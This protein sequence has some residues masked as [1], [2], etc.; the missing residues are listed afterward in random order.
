[1]RN[2]TKL[3][4]LTGFLGSGKTTFLTNILN[5]LAG[6]KV[7]VIMNEFGKVELMDQSSKRKEWNL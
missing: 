2:K 6:S 1:M 5:D 4:L 3:Y 7:A